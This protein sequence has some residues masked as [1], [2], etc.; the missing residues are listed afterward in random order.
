MKKTC[1]NTAV[2]KLLIKYKIASLNT[3]EDFKRTSPHFHTS[4]QTHDPH[5][6]H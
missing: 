3:E 4:S 2:R 5:V 6:L 1:V